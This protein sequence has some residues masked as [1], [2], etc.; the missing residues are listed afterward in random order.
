M[1]TFESVKCRSTEWQSISESGLR[2]V[3]AYLILKSLIQVRLGIND[4]AATVDASIK[5]VTNNAIVKAVIIIFS[6][7]CYFNFN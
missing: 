1:D 6:N 7:Q 5:T 4:I 2:S 3:F